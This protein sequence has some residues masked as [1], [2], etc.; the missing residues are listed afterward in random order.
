M[1]QLTFVLSAL[2]LTERLQGLAATGMNIAWVAIGLGLV[3]FFHEL[4]HFAVAKWCD[5]NV[6]RFSIGFGPILFSWKWGETEYAL[7]LIPFGGYVKMLGQDDADPSQLT[8]E[9][10]AQ[11]PRSYLA[12]NVFQRMAII[13]AGVT[14]NIITAVFFVG[15]AFALGLQTSPPI[16]GEVRP[17]MP[18]WK[19]GLKPDDTIDE[20]NGR[21]IMTFEDV[22]LNVALSSPPLSI[23]G[24]HHDGKEFSLDVQPEK[25]GSHP[26]IGVLHTRSLKV[27]TDPAGKIPFLAKDS[28]ASRAEPPFER[29]DTITAID[30]NTVTTYWEMR[31]QLAKSEG[32]ITINVT[33]ADGS[34]TKIEI[35]DNSFRTIGLSMDTGPIA[36][37]QK[38]SPAEAAG[39][40]EGDKLA[41]INGKNIGSEIDPLKLPNM[42]ASLHG[43][44]VE[45]RVT[46]QPKEGG[47]TQ[48]DLIIRPLDLPG[49][50][51]QPVYEGESISIP[52]I[53]VSFHT[54]PVVRAVAAGSPADKAGI[55][56]TP[57][58]VTKVKQV[59][60][61]LPPEATDDLKERSLVIDLDDP[62]DA[63]S[64]NWG[65]AFWKMQELP[66]RLVRLTLV[67]DKTE[68]K[69]ELTPQIDA[70][71]PLPV[72]LGLYM[73]PLEV[74]Q[75]ARTISEAWQ[76]STHYTFK[77]AMNIYLT[78]RSLFTGQVSAKELHGPI[79]IATAAVAIVEHGLAPLMLFLGFL[80]INLAVLN[81]LPI[82]VL[83]GGHMVFLI[84]E[85]ISRR[86]PS[87]KVVI[88]ANYAG[89][90][91][92][93]GLMV[94]VLIL[95][96]FVHPFRK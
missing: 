54:I 79:G 25:T 45:V 19:A 87:E 92:L 9:E 83:D 44:D 96:L 21:R 8:N 18:A 3:I 57:G 33:R 11:D 59:E 40:E 60:L 17:G 48:E 53:G 66:K 56:A 35:K 82:P 6:E 89:M 16:V 88:G 94:F 39:L 74:E 67:E 32:P 85:A 80:S 64:H 15:G 95:D 75:K 7:S 68:R 76:M 20:I 4:G 72:V 90:A 47:Q 63:K 70:E 13:S 2:T 62:K 31:Q 93:L 43:Q 42:F 84:W 26:Q 30:G 78:L 65:Y 51:D 58:S 91:F 69:V 50:I 10:I 14:M 5:V 49:W 28:V 61:F 73:H 81:F 27:L 29:G 22:R 55:K 1:D 86:R 77:Q 46:R 37:V 23:K 36:A 34:E 71:W 12:K 52:S 38:G 41:M 24:R